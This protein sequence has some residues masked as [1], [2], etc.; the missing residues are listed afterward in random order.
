M[1]NVQ[2]EKIV[3]GG[4]ITGESGTVAVIRRLS[5]GVRFV[6]FSDGHTRTYFP[7]EHVSKP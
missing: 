4:T 5:G 2:I 6:H 7:A 3:V 1:S